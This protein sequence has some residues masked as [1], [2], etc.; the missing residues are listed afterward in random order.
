MA[1]CCYSFT[2]IANDCGA[3]IGGIRRVWGGCHNEVGTNTKTDNQISAL[4]STTAWHL[5]EFQRQ[6]GNF[7][8]TPS[9]NTAASSKLWTTVLT[10]QFARMETAKRLAVIALALSETDWIV[11][12]NNGHYWYIGI[13]Y[14]AVISDGSADTG[15]SYGDVN[16]YN[17]TLTAIEKEPPIEVTATAMAPLLDETPD[18]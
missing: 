6:T 18:E 11:E 2:G 3:N 8:S 17:L 5:F 10:L 9:D 7:V 1:G 4:G 12:D 15:T 16:A 13:D 14:G